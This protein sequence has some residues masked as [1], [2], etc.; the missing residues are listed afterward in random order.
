ML[1][2]LHSCKVLTPAAVPDGCMQV[3]LKQDSEMH[4]FPAA[5]LQNYNTS[6][7]A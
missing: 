3:L 7:C 2:V 1:V 4:A 5:L 6:C